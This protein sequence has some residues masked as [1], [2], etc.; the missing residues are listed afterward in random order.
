MDNRSIEAIETQLR[1]VS[2]GLAVVLIPKPSKGENIVPFCPSAR[3]SIAAF[4]DPVE[5]RHF[6]ALP[7]LISEL[8]VN[9]SNPPLLVL[10]LTVGLQ[11]FRGRCGR[12]L[13]T[14]S[15]WRSQ[16]RVNISS[17]GLAIA[18]GLES[19][20]QLLHDLLMLLNRGSGSISILYHLT[21]RLG[22]LVGLR[23]FFIGAN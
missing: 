7:Q 15:W 20:V 14:V 18:Y 13:G 22:L 17:S 8:V 11:F 4:V 10:F 6:H 3:I 12:I 5:N 1:I 16:G 9:P 2:K 19:A 23:C 21:G